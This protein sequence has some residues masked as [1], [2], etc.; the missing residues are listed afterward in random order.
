[1]AASLEVAVLDRNRGHRKFRRIVGPALTSL[2][3]DASST[4]EPADEQPEGTSQLAAEQAGAEQAGADTPPTP[5]R[6]DS[7]DGPDNT[8]GSQPGNG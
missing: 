2:L 7:P 5:G 6:S 8:A 1:V 4:A 3:P